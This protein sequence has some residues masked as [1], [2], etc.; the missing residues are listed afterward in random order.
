MLLQDQAV[1]AIVDV[2][3]NLAQLMHERESLF[4]NL[5]RILRVEQTLELP[6]RRAEPNPRGLVPTITELTTLLGDER[7]HSKMT[8][9]CLGSPEFEA[10]LEQC[11]RKQVLLTGIEAH[12][13]V[14]NTAADL[15]ARGFEVHVMADAVGSRV[16]ANK[17]V[18][19]RRMCN[20][21]AV[22]SSVEMAL[23]ELMKTADHPRFRDIQ[24]IVK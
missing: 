6:F 1:L 16:A 11:G 10:A 3:G 12:I 14:Y 24:A 5:K 18:A 17:E 7:P 19:I 23:F 21:G 8:F 4:T 9:S 2:Q 13:C 22:L 20:A 15:L